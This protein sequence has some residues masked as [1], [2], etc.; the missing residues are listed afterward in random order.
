SINFCFSSIKTQFMKQIVVF[1]LACGMFVSTFAQIEI[2]KKSNAEVSDK[3]VITPVPTMKGVLGRLDI[4]FP[5]DVERNILIYRP[6]DN[7]YITSV[8]RNDKTYNIAPG[9]YRFTLTAV[10]VE[11][12]PIQQGHETRLK[13]GFLNV[14]SEG[15]W[16]LYNETKEK[17]YINSSKPYKV[18]L[19]V[20]RYQI[21]LGGQFYPVI[22]KDGETVEDYSSVEVKDEIPGN[23]KLKNIGTNPQIAHTNN[24]YW[25]ITPLQAMTDGIGKLS[26]IIPKDT[27]IYLIDK[28]ITIPYNIRDTIRINETGNTSSSYYTI[29]N[30]PKYLTARS[31][32]IS[33]NGVRFTVPVESGKETRVKAGF[34]IITKKEASEGSGPLDNYF[35]TVFGE[36]DG[37]NWEWKLTGWGIAFTGKKRTIFALPPGEYSLTKFD[38]SDGGPGGDDI[39]YKVIIKDGVWVKNGVRQ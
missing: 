16:H 21:K 33:L 18:A 19:P 13:M 29:I 27:T 8:S 25:V 31:Y 15:W 4:N 37:V 23:E 14:V 12:V 1:V 22:I 32:S 28:W 26:I 35:D 10:P 17:N 36:N 7:K 2:S 24:P 9:V 20:G 3:W 39:H 30:L 38:P 5:A 6:T 34:L 11:N